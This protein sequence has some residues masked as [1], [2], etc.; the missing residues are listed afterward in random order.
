V[1]I[2]K[3]K[4]IDRSIPDRSRLSGK[5]K[6]AIKVCS[7]EDG[8]E[9]YLHVGSGLFSITLDKI[10]VKCDDLTKLIS[11]VSKEIARDASSFMRIKNLP[12][13]PGSSV[14]GNIRSRIE[15]SFIPKDGK[16]RCCFIRSSPPRREP[17]KG[18]HGW[19]H[20]RIW[21]ESLQFDRKSCDYM[22]DEKVCLVCNL[23]GTTGLQGLIFFDDFVGDFET[24]IIHLPHGE[25]IEVAPP[26]SRFIGE[27]TFTNLK[28]EELGLLLFGM[29]LRNGRIGKPVLFG[30]YKYRNDLPYNFGV[31]RY[32]IEKIEL[33][34]SLPELEGS[35]D[36][37][38]HRLVE[39]ALKSFDGELLDVDEVKI[40]ESL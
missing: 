24:K 2:L 29:G 25:K 18:E 8:I 27:V 21:K 12:T 37:Q 1:Q 36:E 11:K 6:V 31:V 23:F 15:L 3:S 30:K 19:R 14:K 13:I 17:K 35:T 33:S 32:E 34:K 22:R 39:L 4:P 38:V 26:G 5:I 40:L 20:Y 9:S 16:I 28:L 10:E 7:K